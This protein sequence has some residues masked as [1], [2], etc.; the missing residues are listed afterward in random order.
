M[1]IFACFVSSFQNNQFW[2]NENKR[3][4]IC[5]SDDGVVRDCDFENQ[6]LY[7]DS[8]EISIESLCNG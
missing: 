2:N 5:V 1:F 3:I 8:T 7:A 4:G 6:P